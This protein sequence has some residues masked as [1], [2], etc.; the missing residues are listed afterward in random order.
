MQCE[1]LK[2]PSLLF[3]DDGLH[4]DPKGGL[5]AFGPR[6]YRPVQRHPD[7]IRVGVIGTADTSE[8]VRAWI[9]S[10]ARGVSGD[11]KHPEFPG[12]QGDRGF[13]STLEFDDAWVQ[14]ITQ[15]DRAEV[16]KARLR[17]EERFTRIV[18]LIDEKLR[19]LAEHDYPPEYVLVALPRDIVDR[20]KVADYYDKSLGMVHRDFRRAIK[21]TAMKY[22]LPTQLVRSSTMDGTDKTH[23]AKIAWNFFTGLYYKAGG[24]PWAPH[25]L[26][27]GTC[28]VGVSFFRPLGTKHLRMQTSL[29]QAFDE[30]GQGLVLRGHDFEWDAEKEGTPSPHLT[31]DQ[32][33]AL[34]EM[35]LARYQAEMKQTPKRVVVH[36]SS[37]YWPRERAGIERALRSKVGSF[38]LL[39][40]QPQSWVRLVPSTTYPPLRGTRFTVGS[41]DYLYTTGFIDSLSEFHGMHVP[42]PLQVADH[43]GQDTPRRALLEEVLALTKMNWNS[44]TFGGLLPIT[45]R[46]ARN[47]A[48][49]LREMPPDREP[50]P[51]FKFY[52]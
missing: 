13:F 30:H 27:P 22:R 31:E 47:V 20:C 26:P 21:A 49:V 19:L 8:Q 38:D 44:A 24:L 52:I 25:G 33:A 15:T 43:V 39:A 9:T 6:S 14:M 28:Y 32:A 16:L 45:L 17:K 10:A 42:S 50:L 46:F 40:L 2:E 51:Q 4:L 18:D 34:V 11:D 23:P 5:A 3:A 37:R 12:F 48:D 1:Y 29:V 41:V 35:V 36:K 7:R